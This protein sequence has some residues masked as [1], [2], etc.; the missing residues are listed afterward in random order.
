[1]LGRNAILI[2]P[3]R[4]ERTGPA[5]VASLLLLLTGAGS[6]CAVDGVLARDGAT[7]YVIALARDATPSERHAA[8]ELASFQGVFHSEELETTYTLV[9]QDGTLT[10]AH[11]R[12][13]D[14]TLLPTIADTFTTTHWFMPSVHFVRDTAR[15]ITGFEASNGRSRKVWFEK[16]R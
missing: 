13:D 10:L 4:Q 9:L 6:A 8:D 5:V 11:R 16:V 14:A 7:A 3:V 1:M 2:Q 15:R 12:H